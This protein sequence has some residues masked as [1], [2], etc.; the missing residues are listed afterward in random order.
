MKYVLI[1]MIKF[2]RKY[3]SGMKEL[4][5][6]ITLHVPSMAWKPLKNTGH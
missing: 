1:A 4:I 2:Y 3:L 5:V 6:F